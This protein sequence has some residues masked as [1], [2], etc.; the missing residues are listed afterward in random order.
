MFSCYLLQ[1]GEYPSIFV[2]IYEQDDAKFGGRNL[3][4][5]GLASYYDQS[6]AAGAIMPSAAQQANA[7]YQPPGTVVMPTFIPCQTRSNQAGIGSNQAGI[8]AEVN[9]A[10]PQYAG[11]HQALYPGQIVYAPEQFSAQA[12]GAAGQQIPFNYPAISYSYPCNGK[13]LQNSFHILFSHSLN[14]FAHQVHH[15]GAR[16]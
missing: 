6:N 2:P 16:L 15:I 14:N 8:G 12:H 7:I 1:E 10:Y 9:P 13:K 5:P 3:R 4:Q 11:N